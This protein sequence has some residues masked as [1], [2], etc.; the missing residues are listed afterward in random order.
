MKES[1][2]LALGNTPDMP[3]WKQ[4]GSAD[5][6]LLCPKPETKKPAKRKRAR[7]ADGEFKADDPSTP[8]VNEAY[9]A[10]GS[11]DS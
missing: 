8:D 9:E 6:E 1:T 7:K 4:C 5:A 2:I 11:S 10:E 3:F